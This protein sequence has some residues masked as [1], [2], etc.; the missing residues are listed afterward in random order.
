MAT[1]KG[2][3]TRFK[4]GQSGNPSGPAKSL[5][6]ARRALARL[7][8]DNA[9]EVCAT[10]LRLALAGNPA[11]AAAMTN[12]IA[13]GFAEVPAAGKNATAGDGVCSMALSI[14]P[15]SAAQ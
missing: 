5:A 8:A 2:A 11:C 6:K 13:S 10:T 14:N 3:G 1:E 9:A 12:L 4:P 15:G 7:I